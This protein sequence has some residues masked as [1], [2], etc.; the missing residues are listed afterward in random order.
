[1]YNQWKFGDIFSDIGHYCQP[2]PETVSKTKNPA[3]LGESR[4]KSCYS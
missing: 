4:I 1:M 3:T 2:A